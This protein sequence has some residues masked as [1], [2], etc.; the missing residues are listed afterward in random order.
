MLAADLL[1]NSFPPKD[2][3]PDPKQSNADMWMPIVDACGSSHNN[4]S[5][6]ATWSF[7]LLPD[8]VLSLN[9]LPQG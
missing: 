4:A 7:Y 6:M 3:A 5:D 2:F 1:A 9:W 8:P